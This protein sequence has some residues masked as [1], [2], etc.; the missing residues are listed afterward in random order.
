VTTL[1]SDLKGAQLSILVA[2]WFGH[3][4]S[5]PS[6][7]NRQLVDETGYTD[8]KTVAS[9]L[10]KLSR[11]ALIVHT[12]KPGNRNE[13][14]LTATCRQMFLPTYAPNLT[15]ESGEIPHSLGSS[16]S[17]NNDDS[18][19]Q[20]QLLRGESGGNPH[21]LSHLSTGQAEL[22]TAFP[23][24]KHYV[25]IAPLTALGCPQ[26]RAIEAV[27]EALRRGETIAAILEKITAGKAYAASPAGR[28]IYSPGHWLAA[29]IA[30]GRAIPAPPPPV[31]LQ[32]ASRY[33]AYLPFADNA[34][35]NQN[36]SPE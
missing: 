32:N 29:A 30:D 23:Q 16:C 18:L 4:D 10:L 33:D 25:A 17:S 22:S 19:K 35:E 34:Q 5:H 31:D 9:A 26:A 8:P 6:M 3:V 15:E 24:V 7:S 14:S 13:W 28:S 11:R 27:T 20:L 12:G 36:D 2:L 1:L 21:S